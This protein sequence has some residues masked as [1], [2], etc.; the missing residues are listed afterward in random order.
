[1]KE[2]PDAMPYTNVKRI[3]MRIYIIDLFIRGQILA[4]QICMKYEEIPDRKEDGGTEEKQERQG[5]VIR[6]EI[7]ERLTPSRTFRNCKTIKAIQ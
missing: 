2:L 6:D 3:A 7:E 4:N 1:M 5:R